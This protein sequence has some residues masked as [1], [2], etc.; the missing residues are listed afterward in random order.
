MTP[1]RA[2]QIYAAA[3]PQ[4]RPWPASEIAALCSAPGFMLQTA[5]GFA[6]GRV[7]AAEAELITLAVDPNA[8]RQGEGRNLLAQF[9]QAAQAQGAN[10]AFLEVAADNHAALAL[11]DTAGWARIGQRKA[12]YTRDGGA[13]ID[14]IVMSFCLATGENSEKT[15]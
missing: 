14:A 8:Q 7:I 1:D 10:S 4:S 5:Q 2:A 13:K 15:P 6:L 12:Y 3:F 11:Y 9:T